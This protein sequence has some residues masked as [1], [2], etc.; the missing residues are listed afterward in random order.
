MTDPRNTRFSKCPL[1]ISTIIAIAGSAASWAQSAK[2]LPGTGSLPPAPGTN[3]TFIVAGDNR[4]ACA[5]MPQPPTPSTIMADA[6]ARKAAFV[7]WTG[8]TISGLDSADPTAIAQQYKAFFAIAATA[9]APVFLRLPPSLTQTVKTLS[10][11]G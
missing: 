7:L 5:G 11:V 1:T 4:P 3:Y 2:P 10:A 8:D 6:K 9:G